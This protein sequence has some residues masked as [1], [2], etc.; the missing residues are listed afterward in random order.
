MV[1][2]LLKAQVFLTDPEIDEFAPTCWKRIRN[3]SRE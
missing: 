1:K 2:N 3:L